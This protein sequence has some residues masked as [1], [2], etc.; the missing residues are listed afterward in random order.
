[1][2][3]DTQDSNRTE[4]AMIITEGMQIRINGRKFTVTKHGECGFDLVGPRGG[5]A[6]AIQNIHD[7]RNVWLIYGGMN[8]KSEPITSMIAGW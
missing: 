3:R 1:M 5:Q 2:M 4:G 7:R 8:V 6:T